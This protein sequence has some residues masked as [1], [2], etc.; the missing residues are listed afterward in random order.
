MNLFS[1]VNKNKYFLRS[2]DHTSEELE[3]RPLWLNQFTLDQLLF[4]QLSDHFVSV[5]AALIAAEISQVPKAYHVTKVQESC[6]KGHVVN[7]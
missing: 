2:A 4:C 7:E 5:G 6:L 1:G 3:E